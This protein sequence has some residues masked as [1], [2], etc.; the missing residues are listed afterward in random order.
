MDFGFHSYRFSNDK[1]NREW[2]IAKM[3]MSPLNRR[4]A[5]MYTPRVAAGTKESDKD[6]LR[7]RHRAIICLFAVK[8]DEGKNPRFVPLGFV[9]NHEF[10]SPVNLRFFCDHEDRGQDKEFLAIQWE[11][12]K[13]SFLYCVD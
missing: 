4:L 8:Q 11:N 6:P 5:V 12:M 3:V 7:A 2:S 13:L 1:S 10:V 9:Q